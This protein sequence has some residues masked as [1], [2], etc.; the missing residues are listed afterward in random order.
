MV[1]DSRCGGARRWLMDTRVSGGVLVN[2][3]ELRPRISNKGARGL[4]DGK[5]AA[6]ALMEAAQH[7]AFQRKES[8]S[9]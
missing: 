5:V 7:K 8:S 9:S 1:V 6:Q 2:R 4:C 3:Q